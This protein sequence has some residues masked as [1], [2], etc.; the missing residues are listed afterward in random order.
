MLQAVNAA[1][2]GPWSTSTEHSTCTSVPGACTNMHVTAR[3]CTS[4][5]F[6]W[7]CPADGGCAVDQFHVEIATMP[8]GFWQ[9]LCSTAQPTAE[10]RGLLVGQHYNMRVKAENA[11]GQGPWPDVPLSATTTRWPPQPPAHARALHIQSTSATLVWKPPVDA[12]D[13]TEVQVRANS[14]YAQAC[15]SAGEGWWLACR[16]AHGSCEV[17]HLR[18]GCSYSMRLRSCSEF[19]CSSWTNELQV[20]PY[21]YLPSCSLC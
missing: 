1:G 10:A 16:G 14:Q 12:T 11:L 5:T 15:A 4:I 2:R 3:S 18:P 6:V 7:D 21:P 19:G 9:P 8:R 17:E 13:G 20:C